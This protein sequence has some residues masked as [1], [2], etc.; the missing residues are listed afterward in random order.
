MTKI[1]DIQIDSDDQKGLKD[2]VK[3]FNQA[4]LNEPVD[5]SERLTFQNLESLL[6]ALTPKRF[7]LLKALAKQSDGISI[8]QLSKFLNRDYK[9]V[10]NDVSQLELI[11]LIAK[12]EDT[13][14]VYTPYKSL[15]AHFN[16]AA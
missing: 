3:T 2:F 9:N 6:K 10:H 5:I 12:K 4:R 8:R 11:G 14:L 13:R 15:D 7:E 1:L 16:L